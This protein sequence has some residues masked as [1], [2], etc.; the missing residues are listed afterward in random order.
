MQ[1]HP[2]EVSLYGGPWKGPRVR[3]RYLWVINVEQGSLIHRADPQL[4]AGRDKRGNFSD[5]NSSLAKSFETP[6]FLPASSRW[7]IQ[8]FAA[9]GAPL[10]AHGDVRRGSK[11]LK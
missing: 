11:T 8:C 7:I 9:A 4:T 2:G 10:C 3:G 5:A 6:A 1:A